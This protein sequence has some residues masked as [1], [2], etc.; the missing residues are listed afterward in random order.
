MVSARFLILTKGERMNPE[1]PAAVTEN[2][3]QINLPLRRLVATSGA[4]EAMTRA[5]QDAAQFL[6]RHRSGDWGEID[7]QDAA[8]NDHAVGHGE[9]VLSAY[10]LKDNTKLWII[11]DA[12]RSLTTILLPDEY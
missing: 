8:A 12:D 6:A 10:L 7:A 4:I 5:G 2:R 9:R 3:S 1:T 11:T